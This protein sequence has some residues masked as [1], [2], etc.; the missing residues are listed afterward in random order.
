M[1]RGRS[2]A[3]VCAAALIE[4][5]YEFVG[6]VAKLA[7]LVRQASD[8]STPVAGRGVD[9]LIRVMP[10]ERVLPRRGLRQDTVVVVQRLA[11]VGATWLMLEL[12][13]RAFGGLVTRDRRPT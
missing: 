11:G 9:R 13:P 3:A 4:L 1:N 7:T 2:G 5:V 12:L 8:L 6:A 10:R